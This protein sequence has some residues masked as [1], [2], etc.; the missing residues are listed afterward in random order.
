MLL[1]DL[2]QTPVPIPHAYERLF[3]NIRN[4][5][6]DAHSHYYSLLQEILVVAIHYKQRG[7]ND[8]HLAEAVVDSFLPGFLFLS[9]RQRLL[10]EEDLKDAVNEF[11]ME[12]EHHLLNCQDFR[13]LDNE[14]IFIEGKLW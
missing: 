4:V 11:L 7:C 13:I 14:I 5:V 12:V 3:N 6:I 8:R 2:K 1:Q 9:E 10:L